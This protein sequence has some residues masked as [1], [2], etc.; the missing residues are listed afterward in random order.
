[1]TLLGDEKQGLFGICLL[2]T[3]C[4]GLYVACLLRPLAVTL[5]VGSAVLGIGV[6]LIWLVQ[7]YFVGVNSTHSTMGR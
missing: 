2:F 7:G 4:V 6:G 5:Y 3:V 1:M